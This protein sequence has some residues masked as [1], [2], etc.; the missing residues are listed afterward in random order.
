MLAFSAKESLYKAMGPLGLSDLDFL[1][2][3]V[4]FSPSDHDY[5]VKFATPSSRSLVKGLA[6]SGRYACSPT[7]V[8]TAV[9]L[10][11]T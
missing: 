10:L 7:H 4:F 6:V 5:R 11:A 8:A 2:V 1:D 3:E 9:T